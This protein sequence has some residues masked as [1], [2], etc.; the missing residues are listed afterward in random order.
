MELHE[1]LQELR[2]QKG[3]TQEEL[4]E[5]LFVSRAAVS[6]WETGRGSPGIDSLKAIAQFFSVTV[7]ELLSGD[8]LLTIAEED[9]RQAARRLRG[10]VFSLL[11]CS[12]AIFLFL[13]FF[14]QAAEGRI[15]GVTLFA[16]TDTAPYMKAAYLIA[17][18]AMTAWGILTLALQRNRGTVSLVLNGAA[19][20]LFIMGSQPYAAAF[21]FLYPVI[22]V[23]LL[24]KQQ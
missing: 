3:L 9:R 10:L 12:A 1:K 19:V 7:D 13:P 23:F 16:L 14:R 5:A 6:K 8:E 15:A 21:S 11:D 4:A 17:V 2:K 22:K 18:I 20:L 24:V